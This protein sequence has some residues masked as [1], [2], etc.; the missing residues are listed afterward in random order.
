MAGLVKIPKVENQM[1]YLIYLKW[2]NVISRDST[3]NN[4][5]NFQRQ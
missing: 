1:Q 4:E 2:K 5:S 3:V